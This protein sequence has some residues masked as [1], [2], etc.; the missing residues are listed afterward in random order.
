[1]Q[2]DSTVRLA[3]PTAVFVGG[4][5]V[6]GTSLLLVMPVAESDERALLDWA[7]GAF[8]VVLGFIGSVGAFLVA[9]S[10]YYATPITRSG[11][12]FVVS[13]FVLAIALFFF[14]PAF[15][16]AALYFLLAIPLFAV[17]VR[18]WVA[19]SKSM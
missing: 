15:T 8:T 12:A 18:E 3:F 7:V 6:V 11:F 10:A 9:R 19:R 14:A 13:F 2:Q 5:L 1:M 17:T 16:L 4:L